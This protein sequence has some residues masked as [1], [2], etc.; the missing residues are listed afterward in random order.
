MSDPT[1]CVVGVWDITYY[2]VDMETDLP[3]QN[4]DG[5]VKTFYSNNIDYGYFTNEIDPDDL[6]EMGTEDD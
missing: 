1:K 2:M 3:L 5:S 4:E 6:I